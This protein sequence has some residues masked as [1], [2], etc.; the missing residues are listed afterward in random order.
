[1][2]QAK[3]PGPGQ[4]LRYAVGG[5]L[6]EELRDWVLRDTTGPTWVLRHI[7]R[8]LIYIAPLVIIILIFLPGPFWIRGLAVIGGTVM[9]LIYS[10]AYLV[11]STE[12]RL[13]KAGYPPGTGESIRRKRSEA[14]RDAASAKRRARLAERQARAR[15]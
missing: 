4:W 9:T 6:P 5:G 11:E 3:R 7:A 2:A 15:R 12:R 13:L 10:A 1:M 8:S 14:A